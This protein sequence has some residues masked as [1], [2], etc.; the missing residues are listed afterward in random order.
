MKLDSLNG[1]LV[2]DLKTHKTLERLAPYHNVLDLGEPRKIS[3]NVALPSP[4]LSTIGN[5]IH[6]AD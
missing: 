6:S 1:M 3:R 4:V 5:W 2:L